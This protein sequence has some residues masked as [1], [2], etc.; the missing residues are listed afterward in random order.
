[1]VL[2]QDALAGIPAGNLASEYTNRLDV[3]N[4]QPDGVGKTGFISSGFL[5]SDGSINQLNTIRGKG[6]F[7]S[8]SI[9]TTDTN[10]VEGKPAIYEVNVPE[11]QTPTPTS[12]VR[13]IP[14]TFPNLFTPE[15]WFTNDFNVAF[16]P[17]P[18][19]ARQ[20]MERSIK[21]GERQKQDAEIEEKENEKKKKGRRKTK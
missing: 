18:L 11:I 17:F 4:L 19:Y 21:Q 8:I 15:S 13:L 6:D 20:N 10:V 9:L 5:D 16:T 12:N 14:G 1:M 2:N 3:F 7:E